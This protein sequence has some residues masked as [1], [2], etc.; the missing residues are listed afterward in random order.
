M[1]ANGFEW[2]YNVSGGRPLIL[3]FLMK[4][5]ET[6]TRGDM[7]NIESGEVD[8]AVTSDA[9]IAGIFVGP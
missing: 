4:A 9:A 7:L 8:L 6:L 2:R 3:T 1:A 5:S